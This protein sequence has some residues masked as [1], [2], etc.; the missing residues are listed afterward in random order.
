MGVVGVGGSGG[1]KGYLDRYHRGAPLRQRSRG[2]VGA[3]RDIAG[4]AEEEV[5]SVIRVS[6]RHGATCPDENL[7]R[8]LERSRLVHGRR[9]IERGER[10]GVCGDGGTG[11]DDAL[12]EFPHHGAGVWTDGERG[13][14]GARGGKRGQ[15]G[16]RGGGSK[17]LL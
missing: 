13:Q 5:D 11:L 17:T 15:E 4:A 6:T 9:L 3:E 2:L 8:E 12:Y 1:E 7:T 14:E 16:A 10:A